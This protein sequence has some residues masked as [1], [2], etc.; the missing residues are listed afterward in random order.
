MALGFCPQG[1]GHTDGLYN[2]N[3][4]VLCLSSELL[5]LKLSLMVE[6]YK[7]KRPLKILVCYLQGQGH[8]EL[9]RYQL[10]TA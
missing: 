2:Q 5:T 1:E 9:S 3:M 10:M 6:C 4:T 8:R 7:P